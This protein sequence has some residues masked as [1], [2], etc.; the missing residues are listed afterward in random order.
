VITPVHVCVK[1]NS[2][3]DVVAFHRAALEAGGK[4]FGAPGLRPEYHPGYLGAFVLDPDGHNLEAVI[5]DA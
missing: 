1:A 3:D 2:R 4:D 5:H